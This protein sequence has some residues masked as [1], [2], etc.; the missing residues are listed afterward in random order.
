MRPDTVQISLPGPDGLFLGH[1]GKVL[2]GSVGGCGS[3]A[4]GLQPRAWWA[5][6]VRPVGNVG[7]SL[8]RSAGLSATLLTANLHSKIH[9]VCPL[10]I[11]A[12]SGINRHLESNFNSFCSSLLSI[13]IIQ[14]IETHSTSSLY[15]RFGAPSLHLICIL[16]LFRIC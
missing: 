5:P 11:K 10:Q 7:E 9:A 15:S 12:I 1:R 4:G 13:L 2:E 3:R 8:P 16:S 6:A 14:R